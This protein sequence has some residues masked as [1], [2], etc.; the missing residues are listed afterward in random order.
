MKFIIFTSIVLLC[1][2]F[3]S[4]K[5]YKKFSDEELNTENVTELYKEYLTHHPHKSYKHDSDEGK[6]RLVHFKKNLDKIKKLRAHIKKHNESWVANLNSMSDI[7]EEEFA[8]MQGFKIPPLSLDIGKK[9]S[10]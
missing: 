10:E 8:A 2:A 1:F 9:N 7:S 6:K 4:C 5:E 3:I